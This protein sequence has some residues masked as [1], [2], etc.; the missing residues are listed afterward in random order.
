L[1]FS[2]EIFHR[3]RL[4]AES[5]FI[6]ELVKAA[7]RQV[8][9]VGGKWHCATCGQA[10][11]SE[12][13]VPGFIVSYPVEGPDTGQPG[14]VAGI[15]EACRFHPVVHQRVLH[16]INPQAEIIPDNDNVT[17]RPDHRESQTKH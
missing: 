16:A 3:T 2:V 1:F 7:R 8:R 13:A 14:M 11:K 4:S 9:E 6:R 10:W 17:G 5:R 12:R 15:C